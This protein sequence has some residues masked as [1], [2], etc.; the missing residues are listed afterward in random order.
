[1]TVSDL[2]EELG[3]S[4]DDLL[5]WLNDLLSDY[6]QHNRSLIIHYLKQHPKFLVMFLQGGLSLE[7]VFRVLLELCPGTEIEIDPPKALMNR[8]SRDGSLAELVALA[9]MSIIA[10]LALMNQPS[11]TKNKEGFLGVH[12]KIR[13]KNI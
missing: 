1:M 8:W 2:L 13:P 6:T 7:D 11:M 9:G 12:K 10:A 3:I 4:E 5:A